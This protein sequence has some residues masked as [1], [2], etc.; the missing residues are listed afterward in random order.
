MYRPEYSDRCI[1][2]YR[3]SLI[4]RLWATMA[5]MISTDRETL[6]TRV[7]RW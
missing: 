1:T 3:Q 7:T 5:E 6:V 4:R 2:L